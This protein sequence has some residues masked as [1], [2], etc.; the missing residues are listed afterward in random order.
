M[1]NEGV[2]RRLALLG[3]PAG[4]ALAAMVALAA[5]K[6]PQDTA[7]PDIYSGKF[8]KSDE[9]VTQGSVN[10]ISYQAIAGTIVVHPDDWNNSAQNG[11]TKNPDAKEDEVLCRSLDVLRLLR[12]ARRRAPRRAPSPSSTM[13]AP[14]H[15]PCGCTWAPSARSAW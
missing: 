2:V 12:Q 7:K 5:E 6:A 14:A 11:G 4:V 13:A 9:T 15:R 3:A 1:K 10:G 8:F